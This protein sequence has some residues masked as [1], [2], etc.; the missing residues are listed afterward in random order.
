M[1]KKL[2]IFCLM[3]A[4][5]AA[6]ST[7]ALAEYVST[8]NPLKADIIHAPTTSQVAISG[9]QPWAVAN[10][11]TSPISKEFPIGAYPWENPVA[12]VSSYRKGISPYPNITGGAR[13]RMG[14][15]LFVAGT[16]E[17]STSGKGFGTTY[18][19][20]QIT[21]LQPQVNHTLY[22]WGWETEGT[23][24]VNTNNPNRK[25]GFWATTNPLDWLN[26]NGYSGLNGEPNGYHP[27]GG[28]PDYPIPPGTTESNMPAGL[29]AQGSR[30]FMQM[31]DTDNWSVGATAIPK[32]TLIIN[33]GGT[34]GVDGSGSITVYGWMDATDYGN[35]LHMPLNGFYLIPEPTTVALLGLGGLAMLRRRKRT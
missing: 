9:W 5:I 30:F 10:D 18:L 12:E 17:Y 11:W 33:S 20:L 13:A 22:L 3:L 24:V 28:Y 27:K 21:N 1:C 26:A 25:F 14:G 6:L 32:A 7:Q 31:P 34:L 23:W 35:S 16:G 15:L 8:T 4:V 29:Y 19:K 2:S